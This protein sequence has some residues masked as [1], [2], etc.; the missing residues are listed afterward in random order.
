MK[1]AITLSGSIRTG[2]FNA[3]LQARVSD[4]LE[5]AGVETVRLNLADYPMPIFNQDIEANGMPKT[6]TDLAALLLT[7]DIIFIATPEY[8]AS[9][10]PLLVNMIAWLSRTKPN[11]LSHAVMG[12][13]GVS[14][15]KYGTVNA[16]GHL[17]DS[18]SKL[19]VMVVPTLL[20]VGPAS[21]AFGENDEVLEKG[22]QVKIERIV[23][24]MT[25]F[26]RGGL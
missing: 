16:Q 23:A 9:L 17:R 3:K 25:H 1:K 4:A 22:V 26:S 5:Q 15:G 21:T 19:G 14:S 11:P 20:G 2:S 10:P 7:A 12:I 24:E 18:L 8:N 13:G 6:V